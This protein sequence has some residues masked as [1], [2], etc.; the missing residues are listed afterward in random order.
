MCLS[1][2]L[3]Q[4]PEPQFSPE[5][6]PVPIQVVDAAQVYPDLTRAIEFA[7]SVFDHSGIATNWLP[8]CVLNGKKGDRGRSKCASKPPDWPKPI[9]ICIFDENGYSPDIDS[10]VLAESHPRER[11]IFVLMERITR[12]ALARNNRRAALLG[13]VMA[14]EIGHTLG[15]KHAP[16]GIM[17]PEVRWQELMDEITGELTFSISESKQ[18]RVSN[19]VVETFPDTQER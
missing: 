2:A 1:L 9:E 4:I 12:S 7:K 8:A 6:A 14:H 15:L 17:R 5:D 11:R 16:T 13:L 19:R 18:I 3:A 10:T